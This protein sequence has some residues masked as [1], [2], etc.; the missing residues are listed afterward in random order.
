M[1]NKWGVFLRVLSPRE[2]CF[3]HVHSGTSPGRGAFVYWCGDVATVK[4]SNFGLGWGCVHA[5][6]LARLGPGGARL[7]A[8]VRRVARLGSG[9]A[10]LGPGGARPSAVVRWVLRVDGGVAR[11]WATFNMISQRLIVVLDDVYH[12]RWMRGRILGGG[13]GMRPGTGNV[14]SE[15]RMNY[16]S[17]FRASGSRRIRRA[18]EGTGSGDLPSD[19]SKER[20]PW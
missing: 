15:A 6:G 7:G 18:S 14:C 2:A 10:S 1:L 11:W 3:R 20:C 9:L 17:W 13:G 4:P 19:V 8:V 5:V 16:P 12:T